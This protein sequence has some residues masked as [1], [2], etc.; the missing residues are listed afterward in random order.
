VRPDGKQEIDYRQQC[1]EAAKTE[2][3]FG[4]FCHVILH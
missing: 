4:H 3:K 2:E 1:P